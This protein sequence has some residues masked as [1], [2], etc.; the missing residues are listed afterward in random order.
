MLD[1]V[2]AEEFYS[3]DAGVEGSQPREYLLES[4][5]RR[6]TW[7]VGAA[8]PLSA[9]HRLR[10]TPGR[11]ARIEAQEADLFSGTPHARKSSARRPRTL[12]R[13]PPKTPREGC[14][15]PRQHRLRVHEASEVRRKDAQRGA[16]HQ[17]AL[18]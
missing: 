12:P 2:E 3:P 4:G 5:A 13:K 17:L 8:T 7:V 1:D 11:L 18:P 14:H 9:G 6:N 16:R 10:A 15:G